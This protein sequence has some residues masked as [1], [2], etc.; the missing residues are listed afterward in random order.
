MAQDGSGRIPYLRGFLTF[1]GYLI[2]GLLV[3]LGAV[4]FG[5]QLLAVPAGLGLIFGAAFQARPRQALAWLGGWLGVSMAS[6]FSY[7]WGLAPTIFMPNPPLL[8]V[9]VIGL[10]AL[11]YLVGRGLELATQRRGTGEAR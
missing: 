6:W 9:M 10:A 1:L 7:V 8:L 3:V 11:G 2:G 4:S 5:L